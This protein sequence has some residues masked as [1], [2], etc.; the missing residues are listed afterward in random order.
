MKTKMKSIPAIGLIVTLSFLLCIPLNSGRNAITSGPAGISTQSELDSAPEP[1]PGAMEFVS[2]AQNKAKKKGVHWLVWT[3]TA[4]AIVATVLYFTIIKKP[5]RSLTVTV[6]EGAEGSPA[7][8]T[9]AFK[10]GSILS[11]QYG[12]KPGYENLVVKVDGVTAPASGTITMDQDRTLTATCGEGF[13]EDFTTGA[14]P[15]WNPRS[16]TAWSIANSVYICQS[17]ISEIDWSIFNHQLSKSSYTV[18]VRLRRCSGN[19]Y[20]GDYILLTTTGSGINTSGYVFS[21]NTLGFGYVWKARNYTFHENQGDSSP[22]QLPTISGHIITGFNSWNIVRIVRNG[23]AFSYYING[24]LVYTFTD[25]TYDPR[26]IGVATQI[27]SQEVR[28]EF[29][30]VHVTVN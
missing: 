19:S 9:H 11:Y 21:L 10:K 18:E 3:G 13:H 12:A 5:E 14:S 8:G 6:G 22:I 4:V 24:N 23:A 16:A 28:M 15:A 27:S 29:D 1:A 25:S 2:R 30:Y 7:G 26:F 20:S 17:N